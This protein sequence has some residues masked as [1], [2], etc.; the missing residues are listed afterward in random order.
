MY[1][2]APL[3]GTT[4]GPPP[5]FASGDSLFASLCWTGSSD[6]Q[7]DVVSPR[8]RSSSPL[9]TSS[10]FAAARHPDSL[11]ARP[12]DATTSRQQWEKEGGAVHD[13]LGGH[14]GGGGGSSRSELTQQVLARRRWTSANDAVGDREMTTSVAGKD[15]D[16]LAPPRAD[17]NLN[18]GV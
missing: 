7:C 14:G 9:D 3:Y 11:V 6:L 13:G 2:P 18:W 8:T 17:T 15:D 10:S 4:I 16:S 12:A 1:S 5:R